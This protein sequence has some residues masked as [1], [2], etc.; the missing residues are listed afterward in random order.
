MIFSEAISQAQANVHRRW[1][2][3]WVQSLPFLRWLRPPVHRLDSLSETKNPSRRCAPRTRRT[4]NGNRS[5]S[6][7]FSFA[8]R[9]IERSDSPFNASPSHAPT[10]RTEIISYTIPFDPFHFFRAAVAVQRALFSASI[11]I[12]FFFSAF[13]SL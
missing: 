11:F 4:A 8:H 10:L 9:C 3:V 6:S 13:I 2:C 7:I 1:P 5:R 12:E